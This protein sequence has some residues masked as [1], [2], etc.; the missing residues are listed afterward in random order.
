[1]SVNEDSSCFVKYSIIAPPTVD[2]ECN[3]Q[4]LEK[5]KSK[6]QQA[7]KYDV[8]EFCKW[9]HGFYKVSRSAFHVTCNELWSIRGNTLKL[10]KSRHCFSVWVNNFANRIVNLWNSLPNDSVVAS[11][12]DSFKRGLDSTIFNVRP[13]KF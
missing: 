1:M 12:V 9:I 7:L 13:T 10:H 6:W 3:W 11:S 8:I 4:Y 5:K 2:K